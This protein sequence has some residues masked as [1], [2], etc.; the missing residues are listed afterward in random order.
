MTNSKKLPFLLGLFLSVVFCG[1]AAAQGGKTITGVVLSQDQTALA[2]VSVSVPQSSTGTIT[3][4]KGL[5]HFR[6]QRL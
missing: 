6:C 5:F 2:G 3:D 1:L 4:D